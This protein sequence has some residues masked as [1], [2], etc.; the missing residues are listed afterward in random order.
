MMLLLYNVCYL[1]NP[2]GAVPPLKE[3]GAFAKAAEDNPN[4][5]SAADLTM[6]G[7]GNL[8]GGNQD[9]SAADSA[10]AIAII[11]PPMTATVPIMNIQ[12]KQG[13]SKPALTKA[14]QKVYER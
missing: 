5:T 12:L 10:A 11:Q 6:K 1:A 8:M 7:L 3:L 9:I 14:R 2:V 4:D 13:Q